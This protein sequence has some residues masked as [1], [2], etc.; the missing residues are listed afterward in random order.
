MRFLEC[1]YCETKVPYFAKKCPKCGKN[2]F[3]KKTWTTEGYVIFLVL[4][5]I[6]GVM[7]FCR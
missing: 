1:K 5:I 2:I 6:L 3:G 7:I 4:L